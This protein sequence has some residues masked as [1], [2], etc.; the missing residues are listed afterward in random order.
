[1][2][3]SSNCVRGKSNANIGYYHS[4]NL[5][6]SGMKIFSRSPMSGKA[7]KLLLVLYN[8]ELSYLALLLH[9]LVKS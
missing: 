9:S 8:W 6:T 5:A 7:K 4:R 1:V 3:Q 2:I